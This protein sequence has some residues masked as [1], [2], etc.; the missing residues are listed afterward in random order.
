MKYICYKIILVTK[1]EKIDIYLKT[2]IVGGS[3]GEFFLMVNYIDIHQLNLGPFF[4][5]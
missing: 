4:K 1:F 5:V 2:R 3:F